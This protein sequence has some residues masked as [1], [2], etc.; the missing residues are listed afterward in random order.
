[1]IYLFN[2][3]VLIIP[4]FQIKKEV[5]MSTKKEVTPLQKSNFLQNQLRAKKLVSQEKEKKEKQKQDFANL[6]KTSS[7]KDLF[8]SDGTVMLKQDEHIGP[9]VDFWYYKLNTDFFKKSG[10]TLEKFHTNLNASTSGANIV[11]VEYYINQKNAFIIFVKYHFKHIRLYSNKGRT[12]LFTY[13]FVNTKSEIF[14]YD[15][16]SDC[17]LMKTSTFTPS[18][19][20][21]MLLLSNKTF[22]AKSSKNRIFSITSQSDSSVFED[23]PISDIHLL[24]KQLL[25]I[26]L[27]Q[28]KGSH[29]PSNSKVKIETAFLGYSDDLVT[30]QTEVKVNYKYSGIFETSEKLLMYEIVLYFSE[31]PEKKVKAQFSLTETEKE[32]KIT[33]GN[34]SSDIIVFETVKEEIEKNS[35]HYK[36][37]YRKKFGENGM[38]ELAKVIWEN[39]CICSSFYDFPMLKDSFKGIYVEHFKVNTENVYKS[40]HFEQISDY[41]LEYNG[42]QFIQT[43]IYS[44]TYKGKLYLIKVSGSYLAYTYSD[45]S[46]VVYL[47]A[48]SIKDIDISIFKPVSEEEID[49][50]LQD[51]SNPMFK[52]NV[53]NFSSAYS[54]KPIPRDK[55]IGRNFWKDVF[56]DFVIKT[57]GKKENYQMIEIDDDTIYQKV[58]D[59]IKET[60][61]ETSN[62]SFSTHYPF[63]YN[64]DEQPKTRIPFVSTGLIYGAYF[65]DGFNK[66]SVNSPMKGNCDYSYSSG[67]DLFKVVF[68]NKVPCYQT[69]LYNLFDNY[70]SFSYRDA[71]IQTSQYQILGENDFW[72]ACINFLLS[73]SCE[74]FFK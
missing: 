23:V 8:E 21:A 35:L 58:L 33:F 6:F 11:Y 27:E 18:V 56:S 14:Y 9:S 38:S 70:N 69:T 37:F 57:E 40:L 5:F 64:D 15:N 68:D 29:V 54:S 30:V 62:F 61:V 59:C 32:Q 28:Y 3:N 39:S 43:A 7:K 25:D 36:V 22:N 16:Y 41:S 4:L 53:L 20:G 10:I 49:L 67:D 47:P 60:R 55:Y 17:K 26:L 1:M 19:S 71:E 24:P 73:I 66:I 51:S 50:F 31:H 2:F 46:T 52:R 42:K 72:N 63:G 74:D 12:D 48:F 13:A 44:V 45:Y 65:D 34:I